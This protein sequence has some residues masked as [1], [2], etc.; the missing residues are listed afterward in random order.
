V[1]AKNKRET[2]QAETRR[3]WVVPEVR[4]IELRSATVGDS[5]GGGDTGESFGA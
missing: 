2:E 1:D 5:L 3:P 4:E